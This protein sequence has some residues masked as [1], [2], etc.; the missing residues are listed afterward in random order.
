M[1]QEWTIARVLPGEKPWKNGISYY[2][3]E[4]QGYVRPVSIGKK[5]RPQSGQT[6]YGDIEETPEG[7]SDKFVRADR[8]LEAGSQTSFTAP[9]TQGSSQVAQDTSRASIERQQ[10]L[11][12]AVAFVNGQDEYNKDIDRLAAVIAVAE[13]FD[14][15][16]AKGRLNQVL[17]NAQFEAKQKRAIEQK[18]AEVFKPDVDDTLPPVDL[19][20]NLG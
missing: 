7:L 12:Q 10:A 13:D 3:V 19:Y 4:L 5:S 15:F 1:A 11:I 2:D 9:R 17:E 14:R 20:D 16:L 8:P 6:I 18:V